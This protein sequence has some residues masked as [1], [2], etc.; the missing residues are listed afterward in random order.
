M[1]HSDFGENYDNCFINLVI[2]S[3]AFLKAKKENL[4]SPSPAILEVLKKAEK[5]H[6]EAVEAFKKEKSLIPDSHFTLEQHADHRMLIFHSL[7]EWFDEESKN[8][9]YYVHPRTILNRT[10]P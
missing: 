3:D 4:L 8:G 9:V 2:A 5:K 1:D 7:K 6:Y 10:L